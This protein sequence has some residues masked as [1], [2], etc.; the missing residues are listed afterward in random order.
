MRP[1]SVFLV[2]DT[3]ANGNDRGWTDDDA[4]AVRDLHHGV[5]NPGLSQLCL[6]LEPCR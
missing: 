2:W 5:I 4:S 1:P 6:I 3:T